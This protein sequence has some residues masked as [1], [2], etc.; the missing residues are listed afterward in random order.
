MRWACILLPHLAL[1]GVGPRIGQER[2]DLLG[3]GRQAHEVETFREY[4]YG[5][6]VLRSLDAQEAAGRLG[7]TGVLG[8]LLYGP[9]ARV[10]PAR[11]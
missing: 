3:R 8:G 9:A 1:D 11:A 5:E 4:G 2:V 7:A 6:D 10:Q